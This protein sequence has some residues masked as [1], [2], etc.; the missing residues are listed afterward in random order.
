MAEKK[1]EKKYVSDA[2]LEK[3]LDK[4]LKED[5]ELLAKLH[6]L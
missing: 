6:Y 2:L 3:L 5:K 1:K 4:V